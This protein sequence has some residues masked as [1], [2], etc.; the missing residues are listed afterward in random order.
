M[1]IRTSSS[2][3]NSSS[4]KSNNFEG[5]QPRSNEAQ[6]SWKNG[7]GERRELEEN[8][9]GLLSRIRVRGTRVLKLIADSP[10]DHQ[11]AL[12]QNQIEEQKSEERRLWDLKD[13][14]NL[15]LE[16]QR[17]S[18]RRIRDSRVLN[19]NFW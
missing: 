7:S 19:E 12:G 9:T 10:S 15:D 1:E 4:C 17:S 14:G 8:G 11:T 6:Y 16:D 2:N 5:M 3:N 13:R 18:V